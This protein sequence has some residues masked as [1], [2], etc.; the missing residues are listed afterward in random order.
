MK[1][2][3][4]CLERR[5]GFAV[6]SDDRAQGD[7][8]FPKGS[9]QWEITLCHCQAPSWIVVSVLDRV[10]PKLIAFVQAFAIHPADESTL[11]RFTQGRAPHCAPAPLGV[12]T[13]ARFQ[14]NHATAAP[15]D[16][17]VRSE[18]NRRGD[19]LSSCTT[20]HALRSRRGPE[21]R[22]AAVAKLAGLHRTGSSS[23]QLV[24]E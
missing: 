4:L 1:L 16:S 19:F 14:P 15:L 11:W 2:A 24:A 3:Q 7:R 8:G 6:G 21:S 12:G 18:R 5:A 23:P 20:K 22:D 17:F 13:G 10:G 9:G